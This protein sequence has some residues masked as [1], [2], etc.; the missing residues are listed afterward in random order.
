MSSCIVFDKFSDIQD[1]RYWLTSNG[2]EYR[3]ETYIRSQGHQPYDGWPFEV[4][5]YIHKLVIIVEDPALVDIAILQFNGQLIDLSDWR[6]VTQTPF[7]GY[8]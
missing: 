1:F 2:I 5:R 7:W 8:E 4:Q 3:A 6:A